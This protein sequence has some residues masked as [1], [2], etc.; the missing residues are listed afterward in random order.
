MP[1]V[2][3]RRLFTY[4]HVGGL[5]SA[6]ELRSTPHVSRAGRACRCT[7]VA[8]LPTNTQIDMAQPC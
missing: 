3:T 1:R 2:L 4:R 5:V 7:L 6:T 8:G